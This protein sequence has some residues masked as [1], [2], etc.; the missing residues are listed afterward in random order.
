MKRRMAG[1]TLLEVLAALALLA[2]LLVGV[3]AGIRTA[4]RS[5]RAGALRV[6]QFDQVSSAQRFLRRELAQALAQPIDHTDQGL[7]L[8]FA[9][10]AT[11]MRFVAPMPGYLGRY[12]PQL[13]QL[14][15]APDGS[16]TQRLEASF[17]VLPPDGSAPRPLGDT[18]VL[19]RG[20]H[21]GGF[22]YRGRGRDGKPGDWSA[23]WPDGRRMPELVQVRLGLDDGRDWPTLSVPLRVDAA[24]ARGANDPLGALRAQGVVR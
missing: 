22:S 11:E 14:K 8:F 23:D 21:D 19:L 24:A 12:G 15:L 5:A 9:G 16:G 6:A 7:P 1:F 18:Q 20:I 10:S 2:F 3:Y 17:A 13:L 4:M